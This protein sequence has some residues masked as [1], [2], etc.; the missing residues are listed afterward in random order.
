MYPFED[1]TYRQVELVQ[2]PSKP[3]KDYQKAEIWSRY[4]YHHEESPKKCHR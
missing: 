3:G 2:N 4:F 1:C